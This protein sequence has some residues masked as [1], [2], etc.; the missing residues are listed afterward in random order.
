MPV[1]IFNTSEYTPFHEV[2]DLCVRLEHVDD[3]SAAAE[4]LREALH[5]ALCHLD[6]WIQE[7]DAEVACTRCPPARAGRMSD[8]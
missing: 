7:H 5:E 2:Y 1:Y 8:T 6:A 3:D 4:R